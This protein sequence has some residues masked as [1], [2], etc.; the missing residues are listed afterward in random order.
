MGRIRVYRTGFCRFLH[1]R[2][3]QAVAAHSRSGDSSRD[4]GDRGRNPELA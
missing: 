2:R 1:F 4:A 3:G